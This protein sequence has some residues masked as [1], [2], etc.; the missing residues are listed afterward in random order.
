VNTPTQKDVI[1]W[2]YLRFLEWQCRACLLSLERAL[3]GFG[4]ATALDNTRTRKSAQEQAF[5]DIQSTLSFAA[6]IGKM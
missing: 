6:N 5:G 3:D 1:D 2:V 4:R